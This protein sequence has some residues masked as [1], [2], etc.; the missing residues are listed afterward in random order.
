MSQAKRQAPVVAVGS[1]MIEQQR[2]PFGMD[3]ADGIVVGCELGEGMRHAGQAELVQL[4]RVGCLSILVPL[5][6]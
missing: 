6:W 1:F 3:Q 5:Q 2:Q 4:S